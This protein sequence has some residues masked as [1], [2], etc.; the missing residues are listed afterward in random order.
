LHGRLPAIEDIPRLPYTEMVVAEAIRLYPP[1]WGIGRR[2]LTEQK[3]WK[4]VVPA[5]AIVLL[6]PFITHRDP[7][8]FPDPDRFDP[9][10]WTP[11]VKQAR[12][13]YA[14]F[15]FGGGPRRCI[16]EGFAW[17]EVILV[18]ATL[19]SRWRPRLATRNKVE[20]KALIT[21]RPKNGV[22]VT[23]ESRAIRG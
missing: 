5:N 14:Y 12:P 1:A 15:P 6:S 9:D 7:R 10:R 8:F 22:H 2:A 4:Y 3:I 11:E 16:G 13:Q 17:A 19:A 20:A 21:L 18:L 23:I